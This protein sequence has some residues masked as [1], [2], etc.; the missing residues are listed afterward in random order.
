MTDSNYRSIGL[1]RQNTWM[2]PWKL[3]IYWF[4]NSRALSRSLSSSFSSWI[5]LSFSST[6]FC[7][8]SQSCL[9][10]LALLL[11]LHWIWLGSNSVRKLAKATFEVWSFTN[12]SWVGVTGPMARLPPG[13]NN[14]G[15]VWPSEESSS[16]AVMSTFSWTISLQDWFMWVSFT[17][18]ILP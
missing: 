14:L 7:F 8:M 5:I 13:V 17:W 9:F 6:S 15:G 1:T 11:K 18:L 2:L 12:G 16:F 4:W 10:L 3:R